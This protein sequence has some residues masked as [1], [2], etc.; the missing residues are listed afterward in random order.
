MGNKELLGYAKENDTEWYPTTDR[1]IEVIIKDI[2]KNDYKFGTILEPCCGDG[3]VSCAIAKALNNE[4]REVSIFGIEINDHLRVKARANNVNLVGN[5]FLNE[6]YFMEKHSLLFL[7]PPFSNWKDFFTKTIIEFSE[8][9]KDRYYAQSFKIGYFILPPRAL[10]DEDFHSLMKANNI[11]DL[12]L[13]K[14]KINEHNKDSARNIGI[15]SY[16]YFEI[17]DTIDFRESDR[18][19][20]V[21]APLIKIRINYKNRDDKA[22]ESFF[23]FAFNQK[24]KRNSVQDDLDKMFNNA[25]QDH[26]KYIEDKDKQLLTGSDI[27][28]MEVL[29]YNYKFHEIMLSVKPVLE[30]P[31]ETLKLL[32]I[33]I[34]Q[35]QEIFKQKEKQLRDDSWRAIFNELNSIKDKLTTSNRDYL[36]SEFAKDL[37]FTHDNIREIVISS[38]KYAGSVMESQI[39]DFYWKLIDDILGSKNNYWSNEIYT[40][41]IRNFRYQKGSNK[42]NLTL[43][44]RVIIQD[45]SKYNHYSNTG[46]WTS[47]TLENFRVCA[48]LLGF[49]SPKWDLAS[50]TGK[51]STLYSSNR[52]HIKNPL[53]VKDNTNFGKIKDVYFYEENGVKKVQYEL[54][55]GWTSS[56]FIYSTNDIIMTA[57]TYKKGTTHIKLN[58]NFLMKMT[59]IALKDKN[60]IKNSF[61]FEEYMNN[62]ESEEKGDINLT[63][64][65]V[66]TIK[67]INTK[68][69]SP[70][71][72]FKSEIKNSLLIGMKS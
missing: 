68:G 14:E 30:I 17:L 37:D 8:F 26:E 23:E 69:V 41:N 16:N 15:D 12:D 19:A 1:A 72:I 20:R 34:N 3:R 5:N 35:V 65:E 18:Q 7:N 66:G 42:N 46:D 50:D 44:Y 51:L 52:N 59:Y 13:V 39:A 21:E 4:D 10:E 47:N 36:I 57:R 29:H 56:D 22:S 70:K 28:D 71:L 9:N 58:Q 64:D 49:S 31:Q 67:E 24:I 54:P 55:S 45:D 32:G 60:I 53:K 48:L 38:I 11:Q 61:E 43:D 2:A 25:K 62:L 6:R 27:V 33:Q 40:K 63:K